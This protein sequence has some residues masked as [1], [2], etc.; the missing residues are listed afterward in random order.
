ME[1]SDDARELL[2]T[3]AQSQS[4]D[5]KHV[6][7][8]GGTVLGAGGREFIEPKDRRSEA[9]WIHALQ[10]LEDEGFIEALSPKRQVFRVTHRGYQIADS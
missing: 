2:D 10:E 9:R 1:L 6:S 8:F 3:A 7:T 5:I 4:G